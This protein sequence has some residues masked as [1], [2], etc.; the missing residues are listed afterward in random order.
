MVAGHDL[1]A[2]FLSRGIAARIVK[3]FRPSTGHASNIAGARSHG[4]RDL[5]ATTVTSSPAP[6]RYG[7]QRMGIF[8]V[9]KR[10][11][12]QSS[13]D[14]GDKENEKATITKVTIAIVAR[15]RHS[16]RTANQTI[17]TPGVT[18]VS[19]GNAQMLGLR[20]PKTAA[21]AKKAY[22]LPI[23][24]SNVHN[25]RSG[26]PQRHP[27]GASSHM[28]VAI[29]AAAQSDPKTGHGSCAKGHTISAKA[30]E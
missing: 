25:R 7:I 19:K 13:H 9:I 2:H 30:G 10:N 23:A 16:L 5:A 29:S 20:I 17:A 28:N 4:L 12:N 22:T 1:L 27:R 8:G 26:T 14:R 6:I 11:R 24:V 21:K 15:W 3:L 18:L